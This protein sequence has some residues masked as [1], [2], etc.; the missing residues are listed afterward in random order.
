MFLSHKIRLYPN[1]KQESHLIRACG[2]KRFA[3]NWALAESKK[4]YEQGIKT[5]GYDLSKRFNA[6]KKEQFPF[7][8]TVSKWVVQKAIYD[9]SLASPDFT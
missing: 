4:L 8:L 9:I 7:T 2:I 5:S 3:Y 6:I 1:N